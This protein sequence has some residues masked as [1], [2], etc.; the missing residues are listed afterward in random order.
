MCVPDNI[1]IFKVQYIGT[2][3]KKI[4]RCWITKYKRLAYSKL[5]NSVYCKTCVLFAPSFL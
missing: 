1:Y 3:I 5:E 4:N 2:Q